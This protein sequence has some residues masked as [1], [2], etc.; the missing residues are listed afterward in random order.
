MT[1]LGV[2]RGSE[3]SPN[4]ADNDRAIFCGVAE[5]LRS[6]G[7]E[8]E[9]MS[10]RDF[11]K[12]ASEKGLD[13]FCRYACIFN[14]ARHPESIGLLSK[15]AA[16]LNVP[17]VNSAVGLKNCRR[18]RLS[19]KLK[20]NGIPSPGERV[21][22]LCNGA[23]DLPSMDFPYWLKRG[24]GCAQVRED[25][26]YVDCAQT[27]KNAVD[28]FVARGVTS[29]VVSEHLRGD[30]VK[31]YGVEG[32]DFFDWGYASDGHSKFG[33]EAINGKA[34]GFDFD[35]AEL[36]RISDEAARVLDVPIYGGDCVVSDN[37]TIGLIDFN[38]WPS[39]SRCRTA[40]SK[41]IASRIL[42]TCCN[43]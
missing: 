13:Y 16:L 24:D 26:V 39:F 28:G 19:V 25:V 14:M 42:K 31:F 35:V 11:V 2:S 36:K 15:I 43:G 4:M 21:V 10:E 37:G 33:L 30:L 5:N 17:A 6:A 20:E 8:V 1:L 9:C 3:F 29:V 32:T 18:D 40:A 7:V 22:A 38:D 23:V 34:C 41:A 12:T 27:A